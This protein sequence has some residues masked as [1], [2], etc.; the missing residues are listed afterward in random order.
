[1]Y[2]EEKR[3]RIRLRPTVTDYLKQICPDLPQEEEYDRVTRF[4][5]ESQQALVETGITILALKIINPSKLKV[6]IWNY[7]YIYAQMLL[8]H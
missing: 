8:L 2:E 1:M 6:C 5:Y 3:D 7:K 4:H